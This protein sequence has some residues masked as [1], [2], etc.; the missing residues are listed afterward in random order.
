[1]KY[2]SY[3]PFNHKRAVVKSLIDRAENICDE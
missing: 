1:M 2:N 3:N